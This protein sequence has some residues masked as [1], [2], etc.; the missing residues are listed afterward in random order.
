MDPKKNFFVEVNIKVTT[1]SFYPNSYNSS[2]GGVYQP[3]KNLSNLHSKKTDSFA[4]TELIHGKHQPLRRPGAVTVSNFKCNLPTGSIVTKITV[5]YAHA[6]VEYNKKVCNIPAP[7][8]SLMNGKNTLKY[9]NK[10]STVQNINV[11]NSSLP[12]VDPS[13]YESTAVA[14]PMSKKGKA[15]TTKITTRSVSFNSNWDY[16]LINSKDFGVNINYPT[17]TNND[18]G[19]MRLYYVY[20]VL[21]YRSPSFS[22]TASS[23]AGNTGR[24]GDD[25]NLVLDLSNKNNTRYIPSVTISAPLGF[26]YLD[27]TGN[28]KVVKVQNGVFVWTPSKMYGHSTVSI[29]LRFNVNVTIPSGGS[30]SGRFDATESLLGKSSYYVAVIEEKSDDEGDDEGESDSSIG[31][32]D[33]DNYVAT[34]T[35]TVNEDTVLVIDTTGPVGDAL[36]LPPDTKIFDGI[37]YELDS[38]SAYLYVTPVDDNTMDNYDLYCGIYGG[39]EEEVPYE[40]L[41]GSKMGLDTTYTSSNI[42]EYKFK[43]TRPGVYVLK[44]IVETNISWLGPGYPP[45]R[46]YEEYTV[47]VGEIY[48]NIK[49]STLTTPNYTILSLTSEELNRLGD[50]TYT[51]QTYLKQNTS[52][53]RPHDW[54]QNHRIGVFNNAITDNIT[55]IIIPSEDEDDYE[56]ITVDSTNYNSLTSEDIFNHADYWSNTLTSVNTYEN[57]ECKFHYNKNYPLFIILTGDYPEASTTSTIR[58][59]EPCIIEEDYYNGHETNGTYPV[60]IENTKLSTGEF[61]ELDIESLGSATP[62]IF[63][64]LPLDEDYGTNEEIAIRG[65]E[66]TGTIEQNTDDLNIYCKLKAPTGESRTRSINLNVLDTTLNTGNTFSLGGMGDLWGLSTLDIKNLEDWEIELMVDNT[67]N[68]NT[69]TINFSNIALT[70]YISEIDSQNIQCKI[71]NED[72][73]YY[74]AFL[75]DVDIPAGLKTDVD[76]LTIDGTDTNDPYR[77]NIKEKEITIHLDIGDNCSLEAS[78]LS[79]M[80]LARLLQNKRDK[81]NRPIPKRIEFSHY[82]DLYWEYIME[83]TFDN[84]IEISSYEVKI[85]LTVPSGTAYKKQ[86]TVTNRTGYVNGLANV[87]PVI[88]IKPT[89]NLMTITETLTDQNFHLGYDGDITDKVIVIDCEDRIVWLKTDEDDE[90]GENITQYVDFN[91]D[92][93]SIIEEYQFDTTGCVIKD[94]SYIERW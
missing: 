37:E 89:D 24:N 16:T 81:Y 15:P 41:T 27:C 87:S 52:E 6:K 22:L 83:D 23:S 72:L 33:K 71:E 90:D 82:P 36:A 42:K 12:Y 10:Q 40:K 4:N 11:S 62:I 93:F 43:G 67:I 53:K 46:K 77:Q 74:G 68:N 2:T 14:V 17:N 91:S 64:D 49:P 32:L 70:I 47:D 35:G 7:T 20:I 76:Y 51:I 34:V 84:P 50:T 29:T 69:G 60:P 58:F 30:Y 66:V 45:L 44:L 26:S 65:L 1:K 3:F 25:F 63:Y 19:Y 48:I 79:L 31:N 59:T 92:W 13:V 39:T 38:W 57:L 73:S 5:H 18:E 86:S 54:G 80:D 56:E 55:T 28:G 78:T 61:S 9:K 8:I 85:K 94:V 75:T 88:V 21:E